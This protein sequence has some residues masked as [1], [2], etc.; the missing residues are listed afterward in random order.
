M[1]CERCRKKMDDL[2]EEVEE[3]NGLKKTIDGYECP[4]EDCNVKKYSEVLIVTI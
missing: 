3:I 4:N 2:S 1:K